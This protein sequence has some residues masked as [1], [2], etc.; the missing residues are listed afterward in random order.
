M[1]CFSCKVCVTATLNF[2]TYSLTGGYPHECGKGYHITGIHG[3]ITSR[4]YS[5]ASST[6][7]RVAAHFEAATLDRH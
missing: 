7:V 1:A 4:H 3:S 5:G 6:E 2:N